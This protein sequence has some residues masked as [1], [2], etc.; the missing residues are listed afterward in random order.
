[1]VQAKEE[2][3]HGL[4]NGT[5][6]P[7]PFEPLYNTGLDTT[8]AVLIIACFVCGSALNAIT[9]L[10]FGK[11]VRRDISVRR[12]KRTS[13]KLL[14]NGLYFL[15]S[16]NDF[17]LRFCVLGSVLHFHRRTHMHSHGRFAAEVSLVGRKIPVRTNAAISFLSACRTSASCVIISSAVRKSDVSSTR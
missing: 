13:K 7:T 8:I 6:S 14:Y 5:R 4:W 12:D 15:N 17:L 16:I 2:V 9:M 11:L 3:Q 1:M 10:Y